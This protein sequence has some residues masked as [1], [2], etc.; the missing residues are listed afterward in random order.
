MTKSYLGRTKEVIIDDEKITIGTYTHSTQL[1]I[2]DLTNEGKV[3]ESIDLFLVNT[4]KS[5]TLVDEAGVIFPI[6]AETLASLSG[7]F[8]D[9]ITKEC[10]A[11]NGLNPSE[12]KN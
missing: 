8:V 6:T 9:K 7:P 10:V 2:S 3:G 5:W 12:V 1:K 11:F 4:I